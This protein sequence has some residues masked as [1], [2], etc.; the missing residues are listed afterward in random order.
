M[1]TSSLAIRPGNGGAMVGLKV[2]EK[3]NLGNPSQ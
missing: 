1:Q 3:Q 2:L